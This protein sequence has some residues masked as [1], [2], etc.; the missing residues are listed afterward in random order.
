M[1]YIVCGAGSIGKRHYSNLLT[2]N[3]DVS[4]VSWRQEG[5]SKVKQL[6]D[7]HPSSAVIVA[8]ATGVRSSILKLCA[9]RSV[10]AYIEKPLAHSLPELRE[11]E[12]LASDIC[13]PWIVGYMLRMHPLV[14]EL[15]DLVENPYKMNVAIGHDLFEWRANWD[16]HRS[17]VSKKDTGG[18][19]FELCH[20]FDLLSFILGELQF[21]SASFLVPESLPGVDAAAV[22][23]GF[24]DKST[25]WSAELDFLSPVLMRRGTVW[26]KDKLINYDL[27][28][29]SLVVETKQGS[30][31]FSYPMDR[32]V[33]F[34]DSMRWFCERAEGVIGL[35]TAG[36]GLPEVADAVAL[37]RE[38]I[39]CR[40]Y[41]LERAR[42]LSE[43][44]W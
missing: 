31:S 43:V 41:G 19:I 8:T 12:L 36:S 16:F 37:A 40:T 33:M 32:N 22:V 20:E 39:R 38:I 2:L 10:A 34:L 11:I 21:S 6:L 35:E 30:R 42:S 13:K 7:E 5:L 14:R 4:L 24:S 25:L 44:I 23:Q 26:C 17:Y 9:E 27:I 29:G 18:V 15:R 3:K 28:G 1:K